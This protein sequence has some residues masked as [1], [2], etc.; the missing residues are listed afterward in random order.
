[1]NPTPETLARQVG[2]TLFAK[3][4]KLVTAESC[5]G[6]WTAKVLTDIAGSSTWF[7][8]GFVTYSNESKR[9]SLGVHAATLE[10]FGAVS[11]RTAG[12]M[13]AGALAHSRADV[14][15]AITGI[16]GPGGGSPDKPVGTVWF[17]WARRGDAAQVAQH[18][19]SG[20]RE[21]IR[22]QAVMTALQGVI[23]L[24]AGGD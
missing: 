12:E 14:A 5:T 9:E 7:E 23:D 4:L 3:R 19:F 1:M 20:D 6:G 2:E 8:R 21:A 24:L 13:A 16:A 17:G 22:R 10:S 18:Q 11:E 15:L